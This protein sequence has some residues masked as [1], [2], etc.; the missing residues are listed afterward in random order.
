MKGPGPPKTTC[1]KE[2]A[3]NHIEFQMFFA[4]MAKIKF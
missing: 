3:E 1:K 4:I 2:V